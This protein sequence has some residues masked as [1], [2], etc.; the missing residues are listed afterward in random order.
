MKQDLTKLTDHELVCAQIE[1][2][3]TLLDIQKRAM[4]YAVEDE[5]DWKRTE[6]PKLE[7]IMDELHWRTNP[8]NNTE[9]AAE[10]KAQEDQLELHF[11]HQVLDKVA[12]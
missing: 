1:I 2:I 10:V 6:L 12:V 5:L 4:K 9:Y 11:E 8:E 7:H 3:A